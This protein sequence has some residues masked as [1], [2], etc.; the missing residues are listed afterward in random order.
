MMMPAPL[1]ACCEVLPR[2][3]RGSP[4]RN[5][6]FQADW[7]SRCPRVLHRSKLR[8]EMEAGNNTFVHEMEAVSLCVCQPVVSAICV[9]FR[10][11]CVGSVIIFDS[12]EP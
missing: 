1:P 11:V 9:S 4:L 10:W 3:R 2:R 8:A 7:S 5:R 6:S 12:R